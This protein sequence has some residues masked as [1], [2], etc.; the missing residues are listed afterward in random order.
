MK[1]VRDSVSAVRQ[2]RKFM[3][4]SQGASMV[5]SRRNSFDRE[6]TKDPEVPTATIKNLSPLKPIPVRD[7]GLA[8]KSPA[9]KER[10]QF[11]KS[12]I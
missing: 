7:R 11:R 2:P 1:K 4:K 8:S 9:F 5:V 3:P 6:D 10:A 12:G